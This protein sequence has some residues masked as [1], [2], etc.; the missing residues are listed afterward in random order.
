MQAKTA[1]VA[2]LGSTSKKIIST[3]ILGP[4]PPRPARLDS[5]AMHP[6]MTHP[7]TCLPM[8]GPSYEPSA[9]DSEQKG[10]FYPSQLRFIKIYNNHPPTLNQSP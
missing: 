1:I 3:T 6:M 7:A 8:L 4:P 5:P 2:S 9:A 10:Q